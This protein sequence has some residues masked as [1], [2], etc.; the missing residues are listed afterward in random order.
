[1]SWEGWTLIALLVAGMAGGLILWTKF[2]P[3]SGSKE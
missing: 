3:G 2:G 1:M